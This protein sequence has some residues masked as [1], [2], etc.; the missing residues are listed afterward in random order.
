MTWVAPNWGLLA[1]GLGSAL[2]FVVD[3]QICIIESSTT[4][5]IVE[6]IKISGRCVW[7]FCR[8]R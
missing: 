2:S 4:Y 8:P 7:S 5:E 3:D 6:V 1:S